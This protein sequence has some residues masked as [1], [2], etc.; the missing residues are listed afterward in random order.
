MAFMTEKQTEELLQTETRMLPMP[1]GSLYPYTSF[2]LL[3]NS[4][5]Y[6]QAN[7]R[8]ELE[9]FIRITHQHMEES[10]KDFDTAF[11]NIVAYVR[12]HVE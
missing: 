11:R 5:D 2:H 12:H 1:D 8:L 3:W 4:L 6:L 9:W 10:G 7:Y